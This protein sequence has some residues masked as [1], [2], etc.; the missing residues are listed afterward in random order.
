MIREPNHASLYFK[1]HVRMAD[2]NSLLRLLDVPVSVFD[3]VLQPEQVLM[4]SDPP[5]DRHEANNT[6]LFRGGQCHLPPVSN[7]PG[8]RPTCVQAS[9]E[10]CFQCGVLMHHVQPVSLAYMIPSSNIHDTSSRPYGSLTS[11]AHF[12]VTMLK[13]IDP[14]FFTIAI[15][16]GECKQC[17]SG[18]VLGQQSIIPKGKRW[19]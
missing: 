4:K 18:L 8:C 17:N 15:L 2:E 11:E 10:N 13:V 6:K 12:L 19:G 3:L 16:I 7:V 1:S 9:R 5:A 14:L